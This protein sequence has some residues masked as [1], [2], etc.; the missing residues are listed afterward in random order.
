MTVL[1]AAG[2]CVHCLLVVNGAIITKRQAFA[3]CCPI[4]APSSQFWIIGQL[5]HQVSLVMA[6]RNLETVAYVQNFKMP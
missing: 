6:L 1:D 4:S 3:R 5:D 2:P